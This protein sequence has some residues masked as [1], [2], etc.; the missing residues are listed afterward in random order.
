[1]SERLLALPEPCQRAM[2]AIETDPLTLP[3]EI[4]AHLRACAA[5]AEARVQWLAQE[6]AP[7]ALV[8]AGYFEYL[9]GRVIRKL[10]ARRLSGVRHHPWFWLAA[11]GLAL[12]LG[13]GGYLVGRVKQAPMV[14]ANLPNAPVD[15]TEFI[16]DTPFNESDDP[17]SQFSNLSPEEANAVLNRLDS[18]KP[19][20]P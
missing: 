19:H 20:H 17:M 5:C 18:P 11:A 10:P 1:M 13:V 7:A 12:A 2:A 14:E 6:E 8:P 3:A 15:A 4:Q 9:P 16:S